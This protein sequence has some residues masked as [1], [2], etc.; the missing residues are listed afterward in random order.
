MNTHICR[1]RVRQQNRITEVLENIRLASAVK[2][3][4]H[5]V[6]TRDEILVTLREGTDMEKWI[7]EALDAYDLLM[8]EDTA[9]A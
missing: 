6:G 7:D 8:C 9:A 5:V 3:V 4:Q 1:L 2:D